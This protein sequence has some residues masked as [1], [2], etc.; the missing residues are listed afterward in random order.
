MGIRKQLS[1]LEIEAEKA[2]YDLKIAK[3][4]I[5]ILENQTKELTR[6][7]R[8][9]RLCT[10]GAMLEQYLPPDQFTDEQMK[11]ILKELFR[12]PETKGLLERIKN[13]AL[14]GVSLD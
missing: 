10:H 3:Q 6:R 4:N 8:T 5:H 7:K 2:R 1:D 11:V 14:D 12:K 13:D 9:H